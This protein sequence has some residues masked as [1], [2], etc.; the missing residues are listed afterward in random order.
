[1]TAN[2]LAD[3]YQ[4]PLVL[5]AEHVRLE[6]LTMAHVP[7]LFDVAQD[8]EIWRWLATPPPATL[9]EMRAL[10]TDALEAQSG[11]R[12]LPFAVVE[13]GSGRA[14]GATRYMRIE[15]AHGHLEIGW[16]WYGS[17]YWRTAVNTECKYVL[18]R[19]A[20]ESLGCIRVQLMTDLRNER[21]QRA[22]ERIG[23]TREGVL[24]NY[25]IVPKDGYHRSNVCYSIID[26][27]WPSVKT[28]LEAMLSKGRG[29]PSGQAQ[30]G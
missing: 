1:M 23:A 2:S 21:S 7:E 9:E 28:R 22:I 12:E 17:A 15:P 27:E 14:I 5:D 19:H 8:E 3:L 13:R 6:P 29:H 30:S 25:R 11:G 24:R 20:F 4:T 18:L 10:V 16:T 26:D